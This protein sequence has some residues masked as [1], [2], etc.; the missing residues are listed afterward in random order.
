MTAP[1]VVA[2]LSVDARPNSGWGT[3]T[4]RLGE[5]LLRR[6]E[7]D[8][9]LLLTADGDVDQ[10]SPLAERTRRV[11]PPWRG[12]LRRDLRGWWRMVVPLGLPPGTQIVHA[13]VEFPCAI[14]A[15]TAARRA[16]IPFVVSGQGTYSLVPLLRRP[17]RWPYAT[18]LRRAAAVTVPSEFT[19]RVM[20]DALG[21]EIPVQVVPN[22][23]DALRFQ[24]DAPDPEETRRRFGLDV[25]APLVLS[26]GA[27][28]RR[29]GFDVLLD[30]LRRVRPLYPDVQLAVAGSPG[31]YADLPTDDHVRF[32]GQVS[33]QDLVE[34][35]RTC[36]VFALLPRFDSGY[37][38]GFGLVYLE[39]GACGKPV[40]AARS[41]GVAQAVLDEETGL[42]VPEGDA[43]AA[44][45]AIVRLLDDADLRLRLGARG[46]IWAESHDWPGYA[47][48]MIDIYRAAL[49]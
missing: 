22:A 2:L 4:S 6:K 16:N 13:L 14:H 20:L 34:L 21:K 45:S 39:A 8:L 11:L 10:S 48:R 28:K 32:L 12:S 19:R 1:M 42:L 40:V 29:K 49:S 25:G 47:D 36:D 9:H 15:W 24:R 18:A 27:A 7:V 41:G 46:R 23:V 31:A 33:D 35:Y 37:F 5:E 26:V 30:A 3:M 38:E 17:D 44:A 43:P